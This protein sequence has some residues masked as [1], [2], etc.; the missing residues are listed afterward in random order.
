MRVALVLFFALLCT[1][2]TP[3]WAQRVVQHGEIVI[4]EGDSTLVAGSAGSRQIGPEQQI[5]IVERFFEHYPDEFD[6]LVIWPTFEDLGVGGAYF[7]SNVPAS[8]ARLLGFVNMNQVGTFGPTSVQPVLGQEFSH[9][10]LA[11]VSYIDPTTG[12]VSQELLGRMSAHWSQL[13]DAEGSVQDGIDW[14]DNGDGTFT[15]VGANNKWS[16]LDLYLMGF[17]DPD[18][19]PDFF[20]LRD[21][22]PV[23]G[24]PP[25]GPLGPVGIGTTVTATKVVVSVQDVIDAEGGLPPAD[26]RQHD[27]RVGF[28]MITEPGVSAEAVFPTA[29]QL[30]LIRLD[31]NQVA[32]GWFNG[33]GTMCTDLTVP[34][35]VPHARFVSGRFLE[36]D[37]SDGD[38]VLEPKE[39]A[40][41][42]ITWHNT[43]IGETAG[44]VASL[45]PV[46]ERFTTPGDVG[47]STMAEGGTG[48]SIHLLEVPGDIE[49]GEAVSFEATARI[50]AR[51]FSGTLTF[52]PGVVEGSIDDFSTDGGYRANVDMADTAMAG[53]WD[54]GVAELIEHEGRTLQPNGGAGGENDNAW[55]T[56]YEMGFDWKANDV[57]TGLTTLTSMPMDVSGLYQPKLRY[58]VWY[59]ALS[60]NGPE[61]VATTGDDLVVEASSDDGV[62]WVEI[63]RVAGDPRAWERREAAF[64]DVDTSSTVRVR[65]VAQDAG[66]EQNLV[67]IGID[68]IQ[69]VSLSPDCDGGGCGCVAGGTG[70]GAGA[71]GVLLLFGLALVRRRRA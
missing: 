30:D 21:A 29:D 15:V 35:D 1:G 23:G 34:C 62:T 44:A 42:E 67:E 26:T 37:D 56:G 10:W 59:A 13:M 7:T 40:E 32:E 11:F 6:E 14:E 38:G 2:P 3:A 25:I 41:V 20:V 19:V 57:D 24:G 43:G 33:K 58:S 54:Y 18:E 66:D 48:T 17:N 36:G 45:A 31:W 69:I 12:T 28:V 39:Q 55:W 52:I 53:M 64:V 60:F 70:T 49:C 5:A 71:G 16:P 8:S 9:A 46:D 63:D 4:M 22:V 65:F 51:E 68:D 47:I 61:P 50:E 27:Y